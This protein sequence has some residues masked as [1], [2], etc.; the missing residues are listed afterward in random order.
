MASTT[1]CPDYPPLCVGGRDDARWFRE[2]TEFPSEFL[3]PPWPAVVGSGVPWGAGERSRATGQRRAERHP[4]CGSSLRRSG[5]GV[6]KAAP[7]GGKMARKL[8]LKAP[9]RLSSLRGSHAARPA[10]AQRQAAASLSSDEA[11]VA[12]V[13]FWTSEPPS[14]LPHGVVTR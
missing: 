4:A 10:P 7:P 2:R 14:T 1:R 5:G 12:G 3:D 6:R 9:R 11:S 8:G 13:C